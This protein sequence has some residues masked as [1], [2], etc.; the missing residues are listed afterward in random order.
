MADINWGPCHWEYQSILPTG[1][2]NRRYKHQRG[3]DEFGNVSFRPCGAS[4][5]FVFWII[6]VWIS[7]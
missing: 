7:F 1:F 4:V 5:T 6:P 3:V 2:V